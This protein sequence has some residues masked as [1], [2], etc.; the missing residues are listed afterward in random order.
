MRKYRHLIHFLLIMSLFWSIIS[1]PSCT[2]NHYKGFKK[3]TSNNR[4]LPLTFDTSFQ[5]ATYITDFVIVGNQLSGI[6]IIKNVKRTNTFHVVFMSQIGLKY[7][8]MTIAM[9]K[10]TDWLNINYMMKSLDREFVIEAL[11]LNF[12]LLFTKTVCKKL[13]FYQDPESRVQEIIAR[14]NEET[15]SYLFKNDQIH[16]MYLRKSKSVLASIQ[17]PEYDSDYPNKIM[18]ENKKARLKMVM[19]AF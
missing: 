17:I 12:K 19:T 14:D 6:T 7:F 18:I 10:D 8:D 11:K 9:D 1:L 5:K 13:E 15:A 3:V 16:S 2:Y 4:N